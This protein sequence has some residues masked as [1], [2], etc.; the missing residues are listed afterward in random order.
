MCHVSPSICGLRGCVQV[1][2]VSTTMCPQQCSQCHPVYTPCLVESITHGMPYLV[3]AEAEVRDE[4]EE[5]RH[6]D[7]VVHARQLSQEPQHHQLG[8]DEDKGVQRGQKGG[9]SRG[10]ARYGRARRTDGGNKAKKAQAQTV[11]LRM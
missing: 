9:K 4:P 11:R 5:V 10:G 3:V 6:L 8:S 1:V 2:D 7:R